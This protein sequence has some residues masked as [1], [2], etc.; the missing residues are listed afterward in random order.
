MF[1][2]STGFVMALPQFVVVTD[3]CAGQALAPNGGFCTFTLA[4]NPTGTPAERGARTADFRISA[5]TGGT[6]TTTV[7]GVAQAPATLELT[8]VSWDFGSVPMGGSSDPKAFKVKNTGDVATG[9][10][11]L[12]SGLT[13]PFTI[14]AGTCAGLGSS[15]PGNTECDLQIT[16]H[17]TVRG[18]EAPAVPTTTSNSGVLT[19]SD[20]VLTAQSAL[21][22]VGLAL[23]SLR[24]TP[25]SLTFGSPTPTPIG[26]PT[27]TQTFDVTNDGD[28]STDFLST[29]RFGNA[30]ADF[31]I[32]NDTCNG[33]KLPG[34]ATCSVTLRFLPQDSCQGSTRTAIIN[35]SDVVGAEVEGDVTG[36]T[37]ETCN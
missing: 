27:A 35:V 5:T 3:N 7:N 19:L 15:L 17:P 25:K 12:G 6:T 22:G 11:S 9:N 29:L 20:T 23:P 32:T 21:R 26:V 33:Q 4:F 34:L 16:F 28:I 14:D 36:F 2:L 30:P 24:M 13:G 1:L 10:L 18:G 37:I 31:Q 8:P